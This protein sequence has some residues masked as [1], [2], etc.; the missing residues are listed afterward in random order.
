M[1]FDL[2]FV[3][4]FNNKNLSLV[5]NCGPSIKL[6]DG[7]I[8]KSFNSMLLKDIEFSGKELITIEIEES[9]EVTEDIA[10]FCRKNWQ[11]VYNIFPYDE[12]KNADFYRSPKIKLG[13]L[14]FNFWY[15]KEE[16]SCGIHNKH[17]FFELHTQIL[18][19]GEM[20]KFHTTN[21]ES[22]YCREIL[23]PG[24]THSPFY[25]NDGIYPYHRYKSISKCIWLAIESSVIFPD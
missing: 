13:E 7:S 15:C 9:L 24:R 3:N 18:G 11:Q 25:N 20:Q 2:N 22:L 4:K 8:F 23:T 6:K 16:F 12:F 17:N 14:E 5:I 19:Q 10:N 21:E 1:K